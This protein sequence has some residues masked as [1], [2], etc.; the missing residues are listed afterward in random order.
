[1]D[2]RETAA[3]FRELGDIKENQAITLTE[4][5]L[6]NQKL[7]YHLENHPDNALVKQHLK[8]AEE[9]SKTV[10]NGLWGI[11]FRL[12]STIIGVGILAALAWI[13]TSR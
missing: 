9:A 5:K 10:K 3:M 8:Q 1:M 13:A 4:V 7:N 2:E 12:V 11:I 6:T